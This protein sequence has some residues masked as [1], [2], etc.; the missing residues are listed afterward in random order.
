MSDIDKADIRKLDGNL[1]LVFRELARTR[2]TTEAARRLRVTQSTVSHALARLRDL[3]GDPL[4]VRRPHGLEPTQ[5]AL[6]LAPR[7]DGLIDM[8]G[9]V[10]TRE[11]FDPALSE[12]RFRLAAPEFVAALIGGPLVQTFRRE[13]PHASFAMDFLLGADAIDTLR[14]GEVDLA[15]G[16][17]PDLPAGLEAEIL[18]RDRFCIVAC[19]RHPKIKG[20]VDKRTFAS[21]P[22]IF[23]SPSGA[24]SIANTAIPSPSTVST[25]AMVPRWLIALAMVSASDA[26]A[27][28]PRRLAERMAGRLGLQIIDADF[29]GPRFEVWA[30]RRAGH[31]DAGID[32]LAGAVGG[33]ADGTVPG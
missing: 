4:F 9:A 7:I 29:A 16:Q 28:C 10:M 21:L 5:R 18:Y 22:N 6:E 26:I 12:R 24:T 31:A 32:W 25:V 33:A 20:A 14:R 11:G 19:K 27:T 2:R 30:V 8:A 17:F 1:L 13:A 15:L 23:A 3:F